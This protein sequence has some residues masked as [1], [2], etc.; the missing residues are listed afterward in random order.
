MKRYISKVGII[1]TLV[2]S[3]LLTIIYSST[4][5]SASTSSEIVKETVELTSTERDENVVTF[6]T[7]SI[8]NIDSITYQIV[9]Y[10]E[11]DLK[12][13]DLISDAKVNKITDKKYSFDV[14]NEIIGVKIWKIK[15]LVSAD[16]YKNKMTTNK[17]SV[18]D[19]DAI[20][21]K[22]YIE[23]TTDK[24]DVLFS[25]TNSFLSGFETDKIIVFYFN[26][27]TKIDKIIELSLEYSIK[28]EKKAWWGIDTEVT[29]KSYTAELDHTQQVLDY[30]TAYNA[31]LEWLLAN[32]DSTWQE[33]AE[34]RKDFLNKYK[35]AVLG[36]NKKDNG[37][38]WYVQP[39][40]DIKLTDKDYFAGSGYYR[41]DLQEVAL[42]KMSYYAQGEYFEDIPVLDEDTGWIKYTEEKKDFWDI[43]K[44][45][46]SKFTSLDSALP[47]I[48]VI[49]ILIILV[50]LALSLINM[51]LKAVGLG[52]DKKS[53]LERANNRLS[54]LELKSTK[55]KI[56]QL[57]AEQKRERKF[58]KNSYNGKSSNYYNNNRN[59]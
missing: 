43:L 23:V 37:Y 54:S 17:N 21:K 36:A 47:I 7:K 38:K 19:V 39:L 12:Y 51:P 49:I 20:Y 15:Y 18:G 34:V 26:L 52:F 29:T 35:R 46:F 59:R 9:Y 10:G 13:A 4:S 1:L 33:Q 28:K 55:E 48:I 56:N 32:P 40:L 24:L 30:D 8:Y 45:F 41:E 14:S 58:K 22:N 25:E 2:F 44:D 11:D 3:F 31:Y 50:S 53:R 6:T 16:Y 27:D 42:V 5:I 57:K